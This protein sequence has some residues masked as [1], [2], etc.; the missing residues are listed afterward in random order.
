MLEFQQTLH[1]FANKFRH[2]VQ[3]I[4]RD[5]NCGL[6]DYE[7][8]SE[9]FENITEACEN[10]VTMSHLHKHMEEMHQKMHNIKPEN[11]GF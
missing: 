4:M 5:G 2:E 1:D 9:T 11:P 6:E 10:I 3:N 7:Q 8:I